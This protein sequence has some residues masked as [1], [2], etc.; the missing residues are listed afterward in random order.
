[1]CRRGRR[2]SQGTYPPLSEVNHFWALP[3]PAFRDLSPAGG[4]ESAIADLGVE[5]CRL[6]FGGWLAAHSVPSQRVGYPSPSRLRDAQAQ[7]RGLSRC[8]ATGRPP[9]QSGRQPEGERRGIGGWTKQP[10][11]KTHRMPNTQQNL[12]AKTKNRLT[13]TKNLNAPRPTAFE[14]L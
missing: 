4:G 6:G 1:M 13:Y 7:P 8:A 10:A 12:P 9:L 5:F 14:S 2:R 11:K 3:A